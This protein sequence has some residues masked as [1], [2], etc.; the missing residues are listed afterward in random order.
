MPF[1]R[2]LFAD[3][4]SIVWSS[5]STDGSTLF[6]DLLSQTFRRL[7]L[8]LGMQFDARAATSL[9]LFRTQ[10]IYTRDQE[11]THFRRYERSVNRQGLFI[12]LLQVN[13]QA[14]I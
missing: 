13:I 4:L 8:V 1:A 14:H 2:L 6:Q 9:E 11:A 7:G 12:L 5:V 10:G 3:F